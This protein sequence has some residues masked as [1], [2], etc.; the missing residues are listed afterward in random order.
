MAGPH[1]VKEG[2]SDNLGPQVRMVTDLK[3]M[4]ETYLTADVV[5]IDIMTAR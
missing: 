5:L 3:S 4:T 1:Y 2:Y